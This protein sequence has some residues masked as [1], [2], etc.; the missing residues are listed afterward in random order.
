MDKLG[1]ALWGASI[2]AEGYAAIGAAVVIVVV[3]AL[4]LRRRPGR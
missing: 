2:N 1:V 4:A 3:M